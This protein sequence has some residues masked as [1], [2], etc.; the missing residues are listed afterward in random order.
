M[1]QK[2]QNADKKSEEGEDEEAEDTGDMDI[3]Y[4]KFVKRRIS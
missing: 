2:T 3:K 4:G 1:T